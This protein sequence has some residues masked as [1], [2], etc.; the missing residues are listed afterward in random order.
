MDNTDLANLLALLNAHKWLGVAAILVGLLTRLTRDDAAVAWFPITIP[1]RYR[2]LVALSLGMLSSVLQKLGDGV[3]WPTAIVGG[4]VA[5]ALAMSGHAVVINSMRNGREFF[6]KKSKS[7]LSVVVAALGALAFVTLIGGCA[8]TASIVTIA[9]VVAS[10]A[11]LAAQ[12]VADIK[13]FLPTYFAQHPDPAKQAEVQAILD[14]AENAAMGL[15]Q[16]GN[17]GVDLSEA[18]FIAMQSAFASAYADLYA[19]VEGLPGVTITAPGAPKAITAKAGVMTL[20]VP[21]PAVFATKGK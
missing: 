10:A 21:P 16:L 4:I 1:A 8:A 12:V 18:N 19:A 13:A 11:S 17:G 2:P 3:D 9:Q 15:E 7:P 20:V 5:G 6:V 14:R